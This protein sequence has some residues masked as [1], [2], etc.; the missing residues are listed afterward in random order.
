MIESGS[1]DV[2][3]GA[4]PSP[5]AT[6]GATVTGGAGLLVAETGTVAW[7]RRSASS[8]LYHAARLRLAH[9]DAGQRPVLGARVPDPPAVSGALADGYWLELVPNVN[10]IKMKGGIRSVLVSGPGLSA[11]TLLDPH[12]AMLRVADGAGGSVDVQAKVWAETDEQPS[13]WTISGNDSSDI[14]STPNDTAAIAVYRDGAGVDA[15]LYVEWWEAWRSGTKPTLT[16]N[17]SIVGGAHQVQLTASSVPYS[18]AVQRETW[19][20]IGGPP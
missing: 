14:V 8:T 15:E 3:D 7:G 10:I 20:G 11:S 9:N 16:V 17:A 2:V 13:G 5:W 1:F 18:V 12:I 19:A 6:L 4:W